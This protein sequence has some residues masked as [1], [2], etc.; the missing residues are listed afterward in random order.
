M[1]AQKIFDPSGK[2]FI[3]MKQFHL[4]GP[5]NNSMHVHHELEM[6]CVLSGTG[7]YHVENRDYDMQPGDVFLLP[8]TD[9]HG[10]SVPA[11]V[12]MENL[13]CQ[14]DSSFIWNAL[15]N[16]LDYNFLLVFF[17][18]G[19]NF[20]HRLDRSNPATAR[21]AKLLQEMWQEMREQQLYHELVVKI[22]L[23]MIF[24]E[25]MRNFDYV[26]RDKARAPLPKQSIEQ[27]NKVLQYID[28]HLG[29]DIKLSQ[30]AEVAQVSPG[31]LS[32]LFKRFN[33]LP[34]VAYIVN[35]RVRTAI[36]RIR[37]TDRSLTDIAMDCGFNN[38][39]N[40]YKAFKKVTG[41]TP[42]AYRRE[43]KEYIHVEDD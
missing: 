14:F 8:S 23:Q 18:R 13:V 31:Y 25:I 24:T 10:L 40:F 37:T 32:E 39:A 6:S 27:L 12:Q 34:P 15:E 5:L 21:V 41:R 17:E 11:G 33:G 2:C 7:C 36:E 42:L 1:D 3:W 4:N 19:G 28:E 9:Y 16:D 22:K 43:P 35:K 26:D 29:D 30:L 38:N 20:S